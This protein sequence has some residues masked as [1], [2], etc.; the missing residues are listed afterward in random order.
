MA[1]ST[2]PLRLLSKGYEGLATATSPLLFRDI[3]SS[4]YG[5][6]MY[7]TESE[8]IRIGR[9]TAPLGTRPTFSFYLGQNRVNRDSYR[10]FYGRKNYSRT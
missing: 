5:K 3:S 2:A 8:E 1:N 10:S 9:I 6:R 7:Y 4:Y